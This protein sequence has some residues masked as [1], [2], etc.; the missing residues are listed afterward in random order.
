MREGDGR[1]GHGESRREGAARDG[2]M[3][4]DG[5]M[6]QWETVRGSSKRW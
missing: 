3:A 5:E 4:R 6:A 1:G 2:K